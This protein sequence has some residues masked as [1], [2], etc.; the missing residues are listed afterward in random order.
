M[1]KKIYV[2]GLSY[3]TSEDS[4]RAHFANFGAVDTVAIIQDRETGR[5]KGFG[6]VEMATD[7]AAQA[8]IGD[9]N[10]REFEGRTLVVNEAKPQA[11]RSGG[12]GFGGNS[13][14]SRW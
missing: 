13:R 11:A 3:N 7:A 8:A 6:F 12:G 10:G 1:A 2:G 14:D 4:L 9:L 5:S